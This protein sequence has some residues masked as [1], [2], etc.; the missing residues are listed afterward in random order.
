VE[1]VLV[2]KRQTVKP[3]LTRV[4]DK[5]QVSDEC[6]ASNLK[7]ERAADFRECSPFGNNMSL[8]Y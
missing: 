7:K 6:A 5:N 4:D 3:G 1:I 8:L 2:Q